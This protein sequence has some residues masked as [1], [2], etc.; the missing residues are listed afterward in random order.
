VALVVAGV[1]K[2]Y[3]G[4][5]AL[6]E[7][8]LSIAPGELHALVGGNG[9]GKSTLVKLLAGV[10]QSDPGGTFTVGEQSIDATRM[11]P[12]AARAMGLRFV[13]QDAGV[14]ADMS[15]AENLSLGRAYATG[16]GGRVRWRQLTTRSRAELEVV[17]LDCDPSAMLGSLGAAR[18]TLV[19]IARALADV[20]DNSESVL[21]LD[22]PTAALPSQEAR[23]LL[24]TLGRLTA[25]GLAVLLITHRLDEVIGVADRV[26]VLRD[27]RMITS[28]DGSSLTEEKLVEHIVGRPLGAVFP[29]M[30][31]PRGHEATLTVERLSA[32]PVRDLSFTV[33]RGEVVGIAGLLGTGRT[34]LLRTIYGDIRPLCGRI[35]VG[36]RELSGHSPAAAIRAGIGYV[37]E[38]RKREAIFSD[39]S[40]RANMLLASV[41]EFR[42]SYG[43]ATRQESSEAR[44]LVGRFGIKTASVGTPISSLSGGNQQKAVLAR[45]LRRNPA[46]LLL[47]EPTQGVDIGARAEIYRIIRAAVEGGMS[48]LMVASDFEELARVCDRVLVLRRGRIVAEVKPP[49]LEHAHLTH[50]AYQG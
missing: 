48:V 31:Q 35:L 45:W 19:A 36:D 46:L 50:L 5:H 34:T 14:F 12:A 15:I 47:D 20:G 6:H 7:V 16:F 13:H 22:E 43:M 39:L 28:V 25:R 21:I 24:G 2:T 44:D 38:D 17:G 3:P 42:R 4:T 8:S 10:E 40:V 18:Q 9:S 29:E 33:A 1:S 37:P 26:S 49:D 11:T 27:G 41:P 23:T 32:G 30:P